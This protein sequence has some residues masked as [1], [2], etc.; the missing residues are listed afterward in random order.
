[1]YTIGWSK[2]SD[3]FAE[4]LSKKDCIQL[5]SEL[6]HPIISEIIEHTPAYSSFKDKI[7]DLSPHNSIEKLRQI[8][9]L[10]KYQLLEDSEL[11]LRKN[12]EEKLYQAKTG[13]TLPGEQ[14]TVSRIKSE[15]QIE[16]EYVAKS[17]ERINIKLGVDRGVVLSS[18]VA[19]KSEN[20][21]SYVD[22][23]NILWLA[24]N[25]NSREHW[26]R[27]LESIQEYEPKYIRGYGS[28]VSEYFRQLEWTNRDMPS[29]ITGVAYSSD[30]M[31]PK[32]IQF[33]REN[34][35]KNLISLYGQ[36]ERVTM[37]VTCEN[38]DRFH[39]FPK[40]AFT[41]LIREDGTVIE[42]PGEIGEIVG[43]SLFPRATS[44]L[45]YRTGDLASW[46]ESGIC[47]CGREMPTL[48]KIVSR[49]EILHR[50]SGASTTL[51]R[52][53]TFHELMHSLPIGTGI[54]FRQ[55]KPGYL[56]A[57]IQSIVQ[58]ESIFSE[59]LDLLS[60]DFHMSFEI[61]EKP[62]LRSNGKRTLIV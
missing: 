55:E 33:I 60:D 9:F 20:N 62:I 25:I 3:S 17:W 42:A 46:A 19:A 61:V 49:K 31:S 13:G 28:L 8:P 2:M 29:S 53:A 41:E 4:N 21:Y 14:L 34:F 26:N 23:N 56:H 1:M 7:A 10:T 15:Y 38:S 50:K 45:R 35:C 6:L 48:E 51:G 57:Y 22:A 12:I 32:E 43:T 24:C 44:L 11:Y 58:D 36:T 27:I 5:Q 47:E 18:R 37:G 52:L 16:N 59:I 40:Y 54:Q 30:P 39:L